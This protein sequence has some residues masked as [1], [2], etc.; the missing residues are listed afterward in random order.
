M[1]EPLDENEMFRIIMTI[2]NKYSSGFN[3]I[4][5]FLLKHIAHY[6]SIPL[7]L[8]INSCFSQGVFLDS[9]EPAKLVPF[10]KKG[11]EPQLITQTSQIWNNRSGVETSK[12]LFTR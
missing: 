8:I 9:L 4:P 2:R 11:D 3:E 10:F 7:T 5:I 1:L 12:I 6:L